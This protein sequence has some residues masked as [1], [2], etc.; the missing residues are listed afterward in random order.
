MHRSVLKAFAAER[1]ISP[2]E[3][4]RNFIRLAVLLF[5]GS[6]LCFAQGSKTQKKTD[7][8]QT[9]RVAVEMVSLPVVVTDRD[10]KRITDLKKEDFQVFE[11]GVIQQIAGFGA[12]DEPISVA[13]ALDCSGSTEQKLAMIQNAAIEFVNRL[14]PDDSV[15]ILS[16]ASD[17]NLL[18][19][20][21][22]DRD[23]NAYGIKET[24]PGG[25]T[26]LYEAVW[27]AL[28]E[29]LKPVQERKA[30]VLFTDGVD[31]ASR[32]A[33]EK[34]TLEQAKETYATIYSVYYNTEPDMYAGRSQPTVGG[35]PVPGGGYPYPRTRGPIYSPGG[36]GSTTGE[37]MQ[38]RAYL[39]KLAEYSGGVVVDAL[40]MQ[41]LGAAFER[42]ATEL[43]SQYS[44][45]YYPTNSAHDGKFRKVEVKVTRPGLIA[46][47]K[48]GYNAPKPDSK[49]KK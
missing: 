48:K 12:T 3:N 15:A 8:N 40:Q 25:W 27:L 32:K 23:K 13:L 20:F 44:I 10:G 16:F 38:G 42:I 33:S 39:Q 49:K 14:H 6:V 9:I 2:G 1:I 37:Y 21:S 4:M 46:R 30:L 29:V 18:E 11:D 34:E 22:I 24:R 26:V 17:V 7:D 45:G 41:D 28:E 5:L 47:T 35:Y 43:A 36:P 31:T 19:D